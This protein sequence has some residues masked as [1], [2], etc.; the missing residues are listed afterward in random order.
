[1]SRWITELKA[2]PAVERG[3]AIPPRNDAPMDD[4]AREVLF[5]KAQY[6]RR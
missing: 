2:R 3:L 4:K 5:G 6:E 1:V